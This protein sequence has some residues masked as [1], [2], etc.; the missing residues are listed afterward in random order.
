MPIARQIA[1]ALEPAHEA[2]VRRLN[3]KPTN[4]KDRG[5]LSKYRSGNMV[6]HL[7]VRSNQAPSRP[8]IAGAQLR[9]AI[10]EIVRRHLDDDRYELFVF[11]SEATGVADRRS[12]V[13]VGILGPRPVPGATM[14]VMRDDLDRLRTLRPIDLVDLRSVDEGFSLKALEHAEP[15]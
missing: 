13:D 5:S 9:Q 1:E 3:L 8:V 7:V 6:Y 10:R 11:G 4:I 14:Q 12:D 15:L 2:G